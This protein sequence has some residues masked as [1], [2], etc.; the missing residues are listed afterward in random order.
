[1]SK[2]FATRMSTTLGEING[3][4]AMAASE[5]HWAVTESTSCSR[6]VSAAKASPQRLAVSSRRTTPESRT[7]PPRATK[8]ITSMKSLTG[9]KLLFRAVRYSTRPAFVAAAS[10]FND[11]APP[12]GNRSKV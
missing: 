8:V 11:H 4:P 3:V 1:M 2:V 9:A 12:E 10:G 6:G 5:R 7:V